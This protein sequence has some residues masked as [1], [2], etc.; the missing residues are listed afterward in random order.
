MDHQRGML[1]KPWA[2]REVGTIVSTDPDEAGALLVHPRRFAA[3][4]ENGYLGELSAATHPVIDEAAAA[5][6][7]LLEAILAATATT[8]AAAAIL[9]EPAGGENL[10]PEADPETLNEASD[11]D[12]E[13]EG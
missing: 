7:N 5:P 2:E 11:D 12:D 6:G 10:W 13:E 9:G 3:L 8:G 1:L 4:A